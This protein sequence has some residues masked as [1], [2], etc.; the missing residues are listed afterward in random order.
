MSH[1]L[2]P[3]W[4]WRERRIVLGV[5][6]GIAAY[7]AIQLARDLTLL[8][9]EVDVV[10][11]RSAHEFIG[12]ISF[13]AL[14][15]RPVHHALI[16]PGRALDHIRLAREAD[17]VV[18]AP[19][20]AD[21][22]A[23]A[24]MGRSADLLTALLLATKAPVLV[25]PAMNDGMWTHPQTQ[26]NIVHLRTALG[27]EIVG[28]AEGALAFGEGEGIGRLEEPAT[29]IEYIG[30]ALVGQNPLYGRSVIVT[31]GPTREPVDP[32]RFLSNRSSGKMGYALAAAAW[33]RGAEVTLISG[34]TLLSPPPGPRVERV[35]TAREM[36]EAVRRALPGA[37][38]LIMSAAVADFSPK[39]PADRKIKKASAPDLIELEPA[40]DILRE[41]ISAR[42]PGL[43][44]IGFALETDDAR[45]QAEAK[46]ESKALDL[47]VLN[48]A[49]RPGAGFEVDTN[50][51]VIL[52]RDGG[53]EE[54]PLLPKS[55][56]ADTI[57]DRLAT[58][59]PKQ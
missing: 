58:L 18:V 51:V 7:K 26:R 27:Y 14:T 29:I 31:A 11:T 48:E 40:P 36:E 21:L 15:G 42:P 44:T 34:P 45:A 3:R 54:I 30:R 22:I 12:P 13:E 39:S 59:L 25:A 1:I 38:A 37:D 41:T 47:I 43:I 56:V 32:V 46:L 53:A 20:T 17:L 10:M 4:P 57:V 5:S 52:S 55:E 6:G 9:A 2:R 16:E 33:R 28:P 50:E 8:G 19:A 24:A 35:E 49:T 23:R